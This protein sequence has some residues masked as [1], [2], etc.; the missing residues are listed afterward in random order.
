MTLD[1]KS[2]TWADAF[3]TT[4]KTPFDAVVLFAFKDSVPMPAEYF[5]WLSDAPERKDFTGKPND[6]AVIYNH[7]SKNP[8]RVI[9]AGLGEADKFSLETLRMSSATALRKCRALK[10]GRV[11]LISGQFTHLAGLEAAHKNSWSGQIVTN[12]AMIGASLALYSYDEFHTKNKDRASTISELCLVSQPADTAQITAEAVRTA[13]AISESIN[14]TKDLAN[15]PPNIVNPAYIEE[16]ATKLAKRHGFKISVLQ[17]QELVQ[18]GMGAYA[19]VCQGSP[20]GGRLIVLEWTPK[21]QENARPIAFVGKGL[22]FDSG[23]ISLKPP[24]GMHEMKSDMAGAAAVLGMCEAI[25]QLG[26]SRRVV[27]LLACAENMPDGNSM[28]PGDIVTS[29]SGQTIEIQNTD[30][31]GRMVLCDSLTYA[32]QQFN[33]SVIVDIATLTGACRV[34][35]GGEAAALYCTDDSLRDFAINSSK[36]NGDL[37]WPMPLWENYFEN[38]KSLVADMSNAGT[39]EGGSINAAMFL[40]QFI[41]GDLPWLHMDIAGPAYNEKGNALREPGTTGFGLRMM[42]DI[43]QNF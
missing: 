26:C 40:K 42:L 10:L 21:G 37:C 43:A 14:L 22:T 4:Q 11:A 33:P 34:A 25:G 24:A 2:L 19:A 39:R 18:R 6:I 15:G 9:L 38:M 35:L 28:R 5:D 7:S 27:A 41:E 8:G 17:Q 23:G 30:A 36:I 13:K 29:L 16:A 1:I 20:F 3:E 12:E 31:E 32:Q